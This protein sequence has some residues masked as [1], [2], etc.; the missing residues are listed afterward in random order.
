MSHGPGRGQRLLTCIQCG[1]HWFPRRLA[2]P[3]RCPLPD[4]SEFT[5]G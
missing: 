1:W 3:Q 5:L 2:R 4:L